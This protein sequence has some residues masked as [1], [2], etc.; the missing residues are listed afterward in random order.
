MANSNIHE[1]EKKSWE[2]HE[3]IQ[4]IKD[5]RSILVEN[6]T[7]ISLC[8]YP[9]TMYGDNYI[10]YFLKFMPSQFIAEFRGN[11]HFNT[12]FELHKHPAVCDYQ[13]ETRVFT[14][15]M[16]KRLQRVENMNN[17]SLVLRNCE[18]VTKYVIYGAWF[19]LQTTNICESKNIFKN[20]SQ[21]LSRTKKYLLN[22]PPVG[23]SDEDTIQ[24]E[25]AYK[26]PDKWNFRPDFYEKKHIVSIREDSFNILLL[27]PTGSGKSNLI[28]HIFKSNIAQS[29]SHSTGITN[30]INF[31]PGE[32]T[33]AAG[34]SHICIIDTIGF[35][36]VFIPDINIMNM[37]ESNIMLKSMQIHRVV[38]VI[39]DRIRSQENDILTDYK[40]K[41][42]FNE[43]AD[44]FMLVLTKCDSY[45]M[46]ENEKQEYINSF[47][48]L[49]LFR[50][51][52]QDIKGQSALTGT[53]VSCPRIIALGLPNVTHTG[54]LYDES[55]RDKLIKNMLC[56]PKKAISLDQKY[57]PFCLVL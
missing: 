55:E 6:D 20:Y 42:K 19:S 41:F 48:N 26:I 27:G 39:G 3:L 5:S 49:D 51:F 8:S 13:I 24:A 32:F 16:K 37:V 40:R 11:D 21:L 47:T 2:R 25:I 44:N 34:H 18:H 15:N 14:S 9:S 23:L 43:H 57:C 53:I 22:T 38:I 4:A 56:Y 33:S 45:S 1:L 50:Q 31:Y 54:E 30:S 36:D 7:E 12:L 46:N 10:H 52:A 35:C 29:Q 28:N 17:Y